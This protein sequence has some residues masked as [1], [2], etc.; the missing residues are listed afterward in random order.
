VIFS[1]PARSATHVSKAVWISLQTLMTPSPDLVTGLAIRSLAFTF[2]NVGFR[3]WLAPACDG[4]Q[5]SRHR[6]GVFTSDFQ[7]HPL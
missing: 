2:V 7:Q 5:I 1:G 4:Q 6:A 3:P